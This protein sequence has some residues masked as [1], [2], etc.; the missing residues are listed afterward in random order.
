MNEE[1]RSI[2][3]QKDSETTDR[4]QW[5]TPTVEVLPIDQTESDFIA[6]TDGTSFFS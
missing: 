1:D 3:L 4:K 5:Q 2:S 6:V